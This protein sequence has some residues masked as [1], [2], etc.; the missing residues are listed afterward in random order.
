[1]QPN[2]I[3]LEKLVRSKKAICVNNKFIKRTLGFSE[4]RDF[5]E[6][7]HNWSYARDFT[8]Q[9]ATYDWQKFLRL[10]IKEEFLD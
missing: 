4:M 8:Y 1:M 3:K 7:I 5:C 9:D 10:W 6:A 2:L